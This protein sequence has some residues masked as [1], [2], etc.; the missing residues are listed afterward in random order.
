MHSENE[1]EEPE[2]G[3]IISLAA[4]HLLLPETLVTKEQE[5]GRERLPSQQGKELCS[6][7]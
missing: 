6:D 5:N 2:H 1:P 3:I 7:K 4:L